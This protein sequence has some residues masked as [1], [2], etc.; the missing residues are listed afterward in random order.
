VRTWRAFA[1]YLV[2]ISEGESM[3][4]L[5]KRTATKTLVYR[6]LSFMFIQLG[7]WGVFRKMEFNAVVIFSD[8]VLTTPFY[9][10]FELLWK[11]YRKD[12]EE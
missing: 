1:L 8:I 2:N 9:F 11:K 10:V 12:V 7:T 6:I 4:R 5:I 3:N